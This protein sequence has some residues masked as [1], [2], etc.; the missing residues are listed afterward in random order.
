MKQDTKPDRDIYSNW[1]ALKDEVIG[2]VGT[3]RRDTH[4]ARVK[5]IINQIDKMQPKCKHNFEP[6]GFV[7][8]APVADAFIDTNIVKK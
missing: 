6:G 5:R 7:G 8:N 3:A 2:K 1:E 4:E